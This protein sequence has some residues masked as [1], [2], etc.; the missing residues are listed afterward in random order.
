MVRIQ[1][2]Q[3]N[4]FEVFGPDSHGI[5]LLRCRHVRRDVWMIKC[6]KLRR[7]DRGDRFRVVYARGAYLPAQAGVHQHEAARMLDQIAADGQ[8]QAPAV[9]RQKLLCRV[10]EINSVAE[11]GRLVKLYIPAMQHMELHGSSPFRFLIYHP[12]R[13]KSIVCKAA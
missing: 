6:R 10:F 3:H 1:V 11:G 2:G 8:G 7:E 4:E 12:G 9:R 13:I 5:Q